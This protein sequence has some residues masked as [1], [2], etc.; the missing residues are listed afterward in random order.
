MTRSA[1]RGTSLDHEAESLADAGKSSCCAWATVPIERQ[2]PSALRR[3]RLCV[4]RLSVSNDARM[5]RKLASAM[6]AL[7]LLMVRRR[8]RAPPHDCQE[9]EE[10]S[11]DNRSIRLRTT[12]AAQRGREL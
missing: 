3:A 7:L 2:I 9:E 8:I 10:A 4:E 5:R 12:E 11:D 1:K 6:V